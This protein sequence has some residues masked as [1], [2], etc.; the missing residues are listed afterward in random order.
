MAHSVV[1]FVVRSSAAQPVREREP[2]LRGIDL[3][4]DLVLFPLT[5]ELLDEI[6]APSPERGPAEFTYLSPPLF[7]FLRGLSRNGPIM[8]FE[9]E[10]H[11][12]TGGQSAVVLSEGAVSL[13]PTKGEIGPINE[14]LRAIGVKRSAEADEF[15]VV[16]LWRHRFSEDWLES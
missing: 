15:Q 6:F 1:G 3:A 2:R 5:D 9:T 7:A 12:G 4:Q 11:G 14:A 8:Y 10:Y 16:G 13:G